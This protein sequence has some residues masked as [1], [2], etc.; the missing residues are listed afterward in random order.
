MLVPTPVFLSL[1]TGEA[2]GEGEILRIVAVRPEA[3]TEGREHEARRLERLAR[4][5]ERLTLAQTRALGLTNKALETAPSLDECLEDLLDFSQGAETWVVPDGI[6]ARQAL[7]K[8]AA[9]VGFPKGFGLHIVGVD[10]FGAIVHPMICRRGIVDLLK[11]YGMDTAG[12]EA[13]GA[14][15]PETLR[16]LWGRLETD[17]LGLPL[18]VLAEMNW[19]LAKIEHPL[20]TVLKAS[21]KHAVETQFARSF[22][23]GKL[24]LGTLMKDFSDILARLAPREEEAIEG[25]AAPPPNEPVTEQEMIDLLGPNGRLSQALPGYEERTEQ[26]AMAARVAEALTDGKHLV[27]EAGTGVG[28]SLAYLVPAILFAQ[29]AK[30]PLV[31]ST[32]TKNLQ[33][34]LF[35]KD[36]PLLRNALGWEFKAALLKGRPNYLCVHKLL[37]TLQ[38]SAHELEEEE[39][40]ALL[41][42]L[43]WSVQTGTGDVA[44][45]AAF[46]PEVAPELWDRLHTQ[47]E[48]CL[49]RQCPHFN[50]CFVYRARALAREAQVIVVNHAL[51]FA[52]LG[53][54]NGTL[55][56]YHEIVFDEAHTL[57]DVATEHLACEVTPRRINKILHRLFR[58]GGGSN[59]GKGLLPSLLFQL[60]MAKKEFPDDLFTNLRE[61]V[62]AAIQAVA[63]AETCVEQFFHTW[64]EWFEIGAARERPGTEEPPIPEF[65]PRERVPGR[66]SPPAGRG[67][68][69][70]NARGGDDTRRYSAQTL[71]PDQIELLDDGKKGLVA[72]LGRLRQ[73][74]SQVDDDFK[75]I[76]KREVQRVRELHKELSA[77]DLFLQELISDLEFVVKGDEPDYVYWAEKFGRKW[78]RVVAAPLD[79]AAL[80]HEQLYERKRSIVMTSATM[81][82]RDAHAEGGSGL[83]ALPAM[84]TEKSH[85]PPN[86][87]RGEKNAFVNELD[88]NALS[89]ARERADASEANAGRGGRVERH[90]P[91]P[92][93][94]GDEDLSPPEHLA[95]AL[96]AVAKKPHAKSF[97]F[98]KQRL[99]LTLCAKE[100][101]DELLVGSPF[102]Y[103]SQCRLYVPLFLPEPSARERDFNSALTEL[104]AS[105]VISSGGRAMVLYTSY[106]ALSSA[107][108]TLRKS[109][110]AERIEVLAQGEDGSREVLLAKLKEGG[111]RVLLGTASFWQGVDVP[112]DALSLLMIA[113]LPFAV[114]TDPLVQGR[115]ERLE[116]QGKDPFL[117]YSVPNAILKLR[118]GFG[119][120]IRSKRDQGVVVLCDKRVVTR[121]YGPAFLRALPIPPRK[122]PDAERLAKEIEAF[123]G[124]R[125]ATAAGDEG[126]RIADEL[127]SIREEDEA[128]PEERE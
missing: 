120:L 119:R 38:E 42:I 37:Y 67:G 46:S 48:D 20:K 97:E 106:E 50:K 9:S 49:G 98:V 124:A 2:N 7:K 3:T 74:L 65:V 1:L 83:A 117:H 99:G 85:P 19:L 103:P 80:L 11:H 21:E 87:G 77:Q 118:Q 63:P 123:L 41:P 95:E 35:A 32:H 100:K 86:R 6:A 4:P 10:E 55:P 15:E 91:P 40:G 109:L 12:G 107:A 58:A 84:P 25:A 125:R 102:D 36:L 13:D 24:S 96:H 88:G 79:L 47:G 16:E 110:A 29:R 78:M 22:T 53:L 71:P 62:L 70:G 121:R 122:A 54:E 108:A 44:E 72:G 66:T 14:P 75:E 116:Q 33:S 93:A 104:A 45:M 128:P 82:V 105:L 59:A 94:E 28:K 115:C 89:P 81:S 23:S 51:V 113:K 8:A 57:E 17:L 90:D 126:P 52:E 112:G 73:S 101:L 127:S 39:R 76:R 114:F 61:H 26:I 64:Q 92:L 34:Q 69:R 56:P 18:P 30:R 31:I 5:D 43:T 60:D 27:V 111:R 68:R